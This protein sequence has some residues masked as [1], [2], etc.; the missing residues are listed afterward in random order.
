M[1]C[2][3]I[4]FRVNNKEASFNMCKSMKQPMNLRVILVIN[5]VDDEVDNTIEVDLM[6]DPLVGVLWNF[7]SK[8]VE[9]YDEVVDLLMGFR[10]YTKNPIK[11]DLDLKNHK[12]LPAKLSIIEAPQLKLKLLPF[13]L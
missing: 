5:M 11:L 12:T 6:N 8:V 3:E 10:S 4:K 9:E 7:R 2:G 13:H 1:E